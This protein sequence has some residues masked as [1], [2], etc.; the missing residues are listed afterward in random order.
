MKRRTFLV[1]TGSAAIGG[2]ALLGSGAF[3]RVESQRTVT[4]QVAEDPNAYLGMEK[5]P[6]SANASYAWLDDDGHLELLMNPENP[7]VGESPL[8]EGVN[9]DSSTWFDRVFQLCNQGK[10]AVCVY[11][12]DSEDW[13]RVPDEAQFGEAAGERRVEFYLEDDP[14]ESLVGVDNA[15]PLALG[16]CLCVGV[17]T[18]TYG[19]ADGAELLAALDNEI[20]VVADVD[21]DCTG[22][23]NPPGSQVQLAGDPVARDGDLL[24]THPTNAKLRFRLEN[25]GSTPVTIDGMRLEETNCDAVRVSAFWEHDFGE[26]NPVV[27]FEGAVGD[28]PAVKTDG[29]PSVSMF[30][31]DGESF[32]E[33][34][35]WPHEEAHPAGDH[36]PFD[37]NGSGDWGDP[38]MPGAVYDAAEKTIPA[39]ETAVV[40]L[41]EFRRASVVTPNAVD[42][43]GETVTLSLVFADGSE[44]TLD[45]DID[46]AWTLEESKMVT[47]LGFPVGEMKLYDIPFSNAYEIR[48]DSWVGSDSLFANIEGTVDW[49]NGETTSFDIGPFGIETVV[50][51]DDPGDDPGIENAEETIPAEIAIEQVELVDEQLPDDGIA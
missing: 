18:R 38:A 48:N 6:E 13:P 26:A 51:G 22:E 10:E 31:R 14:A 4:V 2:S 41:G 9:S 29:N 20:T 37:E 15:V 49:D 1:G 33:L 45:L 11:I 30:F 24:K 21:L 7:T 44:R 50:P 12:E 5:C 17:R 35:D 3:T 19:L 25:Q 42:M 32:A 36:Y 46:E 47:F 43:V 23:D 39:G 27:R 40:E 16:D 34:E 8:G 28:G